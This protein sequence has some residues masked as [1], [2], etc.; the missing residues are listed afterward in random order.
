MKLYPFYDKVTLA[1]VIDFEDGIKNIDISGPAMIKVV[2]KNHKDLLVFIDSKNYPSLF[3]FLK[4][5]QDDQQFWRKLAWKDC[6]QVASYDFVV[7]EC[8]WKQIVGDKF[9]PNLMMPLSLKSSLCYSE[10]LHQK[11]VFYVGKS[12]SKVNASGI[13]ITIQYHGKEMSYNNYLNVDATWNC[14]LEFRNPTCV[15]VK[16]TNPSEV[17]SRDGILEAYKLVVEADPAR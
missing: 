7:L 1:R 11:V 16:H 14:V 9:P 10:N 15:I 4:G 17:A 12:L 6:E 3:K 5:S 2:A 13:V 8:L